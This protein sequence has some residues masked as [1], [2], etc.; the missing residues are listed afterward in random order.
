MFL[1][2]VSVRPCLILFVV[3]VFFQSIE[4][5]RSFCFQKKKKKKKRMNFLKTK[6]KDNF[7]NQIFNIFSLSYLTTW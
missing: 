4:S 1:D 3:L 7:D 2:F 5:S 6:Q